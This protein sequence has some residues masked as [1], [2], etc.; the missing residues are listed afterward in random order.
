MK[1]ARPN[2]DKRK[3]IHL[4]WPPRLEGTVKNVVMNPVRKKRQLSENREKREEANG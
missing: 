4:T 1:R 3:S 2:I